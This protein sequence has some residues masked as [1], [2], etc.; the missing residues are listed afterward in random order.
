MGSIGNLPD[1][2]DVWTISPGSNAGPSGAGQSSDASASSQ[3]ASSAELVAPGAASATA[4]SSSAPLL[5]TAM[6]SSP[7]LARGLLQALDG[8]LERWTSSK[9]TKQALGLR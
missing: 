9:S 5:P 2:V 7:R 6:P 3:A 1:W 4:A 8:A